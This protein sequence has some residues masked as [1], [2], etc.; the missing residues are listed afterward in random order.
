[1]VDAIISRKTSPASSK[2]KH[3]GGKRED[4]TD[5]G[6]AHAH[7]Q[8]RELSGVG[9]LAEY[10]QE[11]DE[12]G[13][14]T[15]ELVGVDDLV[16]EQRHD[17]CCRRN[18]DDARKPWHAVVHRIQQLGADNHVD[19]GPPDARKNVEYGDCEEINIQSSL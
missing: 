18:D 2:T 3:R 14:P 5:F 13:D 6:D 12:A 10:N 15:P 16:A 19:G 17:E 4:R 9:K 11:G 7:R 8:I 1:M